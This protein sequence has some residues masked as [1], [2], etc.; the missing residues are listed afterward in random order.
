M[1]TKSSEGFQSWR[2]LGLARR[3]DVSSVYLPCEMRLERRISRP[4]E[5]WSKHARKLMCQA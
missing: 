1:K 2:L 4:P 5:S 3:K